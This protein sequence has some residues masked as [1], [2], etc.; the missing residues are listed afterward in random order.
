MIHAVPQVLS[1]APSQISTVSSTY[2]RRDES[3]DGADVFEGD[4]CAYIVVMM[5]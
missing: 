5:P 4:V 3:V 2:Y 1:S